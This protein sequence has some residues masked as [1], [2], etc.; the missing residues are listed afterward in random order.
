MNLRM[1]RPPRSLWFAQVRKDQL[2]LTRSEMPL[3]LVIARPMKF[4]TEF[5]VILYPSVQMTSSSLI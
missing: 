3:I 2:D 1:Y 4:L 5:P